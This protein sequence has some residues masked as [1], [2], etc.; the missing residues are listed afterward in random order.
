MSTWQLIANYVIM[1]HD[2]PIQSGISLNPLDLIDHDD[3]DDL[4]DCSNEYLDNSNDDTV[5]FGLSW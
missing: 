5:V 3:F 1:E 4:L 2:E